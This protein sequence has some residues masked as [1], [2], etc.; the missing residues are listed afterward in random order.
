MNI[1]FV[2]D[3]LKHLWRANTRHGTHSPFVYKLLDEVIYNNSANPLYSKLEASRENLRNDDRIIEVLDLGAG[4]QFDAGRASGQVAGVGAAIGSGA[5]SP[6]TKSKKVSHIAKHALKSPKL[7][8]VLY[9][10]V[11]NQAENEPLVILELGTCLG[12]STAYMAA[13]APEAKLISVEGCP[14]T[15][16]VAQANWATLRQQADLVLA[17]IDLR[18]GNFD[19]VLPELAQELERLDI[20]YVDGNHTEEATLNY[21]NWALE[22]VHADSLI[23]FDDIYWSP[24]MKA[25]WEKIKAHPQV[26][27]T[28][29]FFWIGLVYFRKGQ[30]KEH[31]KIR[32]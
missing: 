1:P 22:R 27:V 28:I 10:I 9:R 25:A 21:F 5:A 18:V 12:I 20:F 26:S 29:D 11:K 31:F 15:A 17:P 2:F 13:A 24:G 14:Q 16:A 6:V 32:L 8:Q 7:A 30:A 3:Y 4:S 23:I 19:R